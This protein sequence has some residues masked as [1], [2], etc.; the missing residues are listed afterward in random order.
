[1]KKIFNLILIVVFVILV[2]GVINFNRTTI[3]SC[4]LSFL[5]IFGT[6]VL[7]K[8]LGFN[9]LLK[10][11][12]Y[13]FIIV[14]EVL[15]EVCHFYTRF[16]W[17]DIII[18]TYSSFVV[19]YIGLYLIKNIYYKINKRIVM[20]FVFAFAMMV[21]AMWEIGEFSIDRLFDKDMQKDTI[22]NEVVS[23]YF[24][25]NNDVP[26][27]IMVNDITI[28]S[29]SYVYEYSGYIDIGLYDTIGDMV[30]ACIGS[31]IFI[32]GMSREIRFIS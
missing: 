29:D 13:L 15:G 32:I 9:D 14:T 1:M 12:I 16:E 10:L 31:I 27:R 11:L 23:D 19:S 2:T 5:F 24:S 8:K 6:N 25:L 26:T 3:F 4:L 17:F 7:Q 30:C 22:I 18:H 28:K 21:E 20:L